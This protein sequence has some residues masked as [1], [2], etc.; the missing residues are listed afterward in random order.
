LLW[1]RVLAAAHAPPQWREFTLLGL[2]TVPLTIVA[3]TVM[4]WL[5]LR[6]FGPA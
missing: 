1:R 2:V 5:S 3:A 4:L 6:A